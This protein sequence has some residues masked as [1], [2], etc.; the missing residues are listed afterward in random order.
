MQRVTVQVDGQCLAL[1]DGQRVVRVDRAPIPVQPEGR[2]VRRRVDLPLQVGPVGGDDQGLALVV[3][4]HRAALVRREVLR[5]VFAL[6]AGV[7]AR[8]DYAAVPAFIG[9]RDM[10]VCQD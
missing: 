9:I 2:A 5:G 6:V 4:A 7:E 1:G 8:G 10:A 3:R